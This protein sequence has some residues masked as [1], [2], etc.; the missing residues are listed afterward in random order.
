MN[1][2]IEYLLSKRNSTLCVVMVVQSRRR[3]ETA[4]AIVHS[5]LS[6]FLN[7]KFEGAM[8]CRWG[9]RHSVVPCENSLQTFFAL[10]TFSFV[11]TVDILFS[12]IIGSPL[13]LAVTIF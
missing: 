10:F 1:I 6:S 2:F 9:L 4:R 3:G 12:R 7:V 8:G 5:F 13:A 11:A